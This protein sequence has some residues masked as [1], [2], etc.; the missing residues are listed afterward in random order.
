MGTGLGTNVDILYQHGRAWRDTTVAT[1]YEE[2]STLY[3]VP[4]FSLY[5]MAY[6]IGT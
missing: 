3:S 5:H 6:T 1:E 2:P 4:S